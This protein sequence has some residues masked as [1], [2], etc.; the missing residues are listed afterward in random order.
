MAATL[1]IK[2]FHPPALTQLRA[3]NLILC[4]H[5]KAKGTPFET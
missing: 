5:W 4:Q 2:T 1:I 3:A